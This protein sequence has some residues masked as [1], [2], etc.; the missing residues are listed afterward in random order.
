MAYGV[1]PQNVAQDK[2]QISA[3]SWSFWTLYLRP[4]LLRG[5]FTSPRYYTH[6]VELVKLITLCLQF[7]ITK[8][9][10]AQVRV[11][12]QKWVECSFVK[13]LA[14]KQ[15]KYARKLGGT[16]VNCPAKPS[17]QC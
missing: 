17:A 9:E 13:V 8:E 1:R 4:V 14:H 7:K 6:F 10:I 16:V 3:D 15:Y 5:Q 11:G 2:S 12:F